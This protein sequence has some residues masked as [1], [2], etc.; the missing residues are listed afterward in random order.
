M[1]TKQVTAIDIGTN[2]VKVIELEETSSGMRMVNWG[3]GQ[4]QYDSTGEITDDV[5]ISRLRDVSTRTKMK[6]RSTIVS[7]PRSLVTIK[8]LGNLPPADTDDEVENII[9]LQAEVAIPFGASDAVYDYHN[10]QRSPDG[11]SAELVAARRSDIDKYMDI[12]KA[13]GIRPS[14]IVPSA[15]ASGALALSPLVDNN[16]DSTTMVLDIGAGN[17]DLSIL[18]QG[19]IAFSRSFS[20]GGNNLT[21]AY[22]REDNLSFQ[23]AEERKIASA[24]L[25]GYTPP[26]TSVEWASRLTEEI[27]RSIQAFNRERL[28]EEQIDDI[29]LCGGAAT[30]PGLDKFITDSLQIPT[31]LWNPLSILEP[32]V[33]AEPPGNLSYGFA[34]PLGLCVNYFTEEVAINLLPREE[35]ERKRKADKKC[36]P[37]HTPPRRLSS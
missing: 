11:V 21:Q 9:N 33:D 31:A 4:Y 25:R 2:S 3:I 13:V 16:P 22:A 14:A 23:D 30:L 37:F 19:K 32:N 6:P 26:E 36:L 5:I 8:K 28:G 29:R 12:L 34:V 10:L 15:Y 17:S 20:I 35:L 27:Q 18:H 7:I 1:A 24:T